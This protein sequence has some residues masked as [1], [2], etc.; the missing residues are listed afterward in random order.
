MQD[1]KHTR[2]GELLA[3]LESTDTDDCVEW[4]GCLSGGSVEAP[5]GFV[6]DPIQS[7]K[8]KQ[9][10]RGVPRVVLEITLERPI[11]DGHWALHSC[12]NSKCVNPRHIYEGTPA[13]NMQDSL[14]FGKRSRMAAKHI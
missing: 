1:Q 4:W 11:K 10:M 8:G 5:Y 9:R 3:F 13:K 2:Y 6:S 14:S 12:H 7:A